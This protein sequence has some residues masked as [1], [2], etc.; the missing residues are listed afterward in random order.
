MIRRPPRSTLFPYTTL[1]RSAAARA[2]SRLP[3]SPRYGSVEFLLK[4][5]FR[6]LPFPPEV[7]TQLLLGGLTPSERS[8]LVSGGVR[9]AGIGCEPFDE[10]AMTV[11]QGRA[12]G[13]LRRR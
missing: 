5:F 6:G 13:P 2:V 1:F 4:Q 3:P 8:T 9:A 7:R 11:G 10:L 12:L